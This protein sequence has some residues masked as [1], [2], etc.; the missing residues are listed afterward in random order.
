MKKI[1]SQIS[2]ALVCCLLGF[3]LTYQFRILNQQDKILNGTPVKNTED[4][5]VSIEQY[6]KQRDEMSKKVDE[7]QAQLKN[8]EKAAANKDEVSNE[9]VKEL[10][11]TRILTGSTDVHGKGI[12]IYIT[13]NDNSFGG[14]V[15][16]Q[17]IN[18]RD[19]VVIV[20]E[21][22][23]AGAEA[24]SINDI[25]LTSRSGIRNAGNSILIN[26]VKISPYKMVEI[27]AIGDKA[28]L[29]GAVDFPGA[30]PVIANCTIKRETSDNIKILKYDKTYKFDYAKPVS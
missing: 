27:K 29:V 3:M 4:I 5:T 22:N 11:D 9:I 23:S 30:M 12:I 16:N 8:Y 24:I 26:D 15:E 2:V 17:P 6:K 14:S 20:N 21:L 19:L 25:R 28:T 13:P 7:L 1:G 18:D 10:D